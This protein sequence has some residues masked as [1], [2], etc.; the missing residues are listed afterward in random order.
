MPCRRL[1]MFHFI[2]MISTSTISSGTVS[3]IGDVIKVVKPWARPLCP[4]DGC[5]DENDPIQE[6]YRSQI[7]D[8]HDINMA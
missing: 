5:I 1:D 4:V 8:N 2:H 7:T 6:I 3:R